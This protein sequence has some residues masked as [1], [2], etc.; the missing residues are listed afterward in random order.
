MDF[1]TLFYRGK[2]KANGDARHK[3]DIRL[4]F[5]PQLK[6]YWES[7]NI[8]FRTLVSGNCRQLEEGK[9]TVSYGGLSLLPLIRVADNRPVQL[10]VQILQ[11]AKT[12]VLLS[13]GGD[14]DNRLKTLLD[15]L[16]MPD[17]NQANAVAGTGD[18]LFCLLEN[19]KVVNQ[20]NITTRQLWDV[21]PESREVVVVVSVSTG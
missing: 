5:S 11:P 7:I 9:R 15:A 1:I 16:Q 8:L 14:I 13:T 17:E 10:N 6:R 21:P 19:D 20:V 12:A 2:L 4:A 3:H 18:R